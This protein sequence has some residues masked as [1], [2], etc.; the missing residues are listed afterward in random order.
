M[1]LVTMIPNETGVLTNYTKSVQTWEND[2]VKNASNY[3]WIADSNKYSTVPAS[4]STFIYSGSKIVGLSLVMKPFGAYA[5]LAPTFAPLAEATLITEIGGR[6]DGDKIVCDSTRTKLGN[7]SAE[8]AAVLALMPTIAFDTVWKETSRQE[9]TYSGSSVIAL[10]YSYDNVSSK[11]VVD[12]KDSTVL[13]GDL[14]SVNFSFTSDSPGNFVM[15]DKEEYT[16]ENGRL[17]QVIS[18]VYK[19]NAWVN[20]TRTQYHYTP[21]L[22]TGI[23]ISPVV[24]KTNS[25]NAAIR[26]IDGKYSVKL[27][28]NK[29]S[30]V[31]V[32]VC[33]LNGRTAGSITPQHTFTQGT[34]VVPLKMSTPG[35]YLCQVTTSDGKV[36]L[37]FTIT[38]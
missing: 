9:Y 29:E 36:V 20:Q 25:I 37:P 17:S 13:T 30:P 3:S 26:T 31:T 28:L 1:E 35:T 21:Y 23:F 5:T 14:V 10:S 22:Q 6:F 32:S 8:A 2:I 11:F 18:S 38:R 33:D 4:T 19:D 15:S 24:K 7:V 16:Y 27:S 34:H 12:G